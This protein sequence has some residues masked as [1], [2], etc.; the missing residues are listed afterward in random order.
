RPPPPSPPTAQLEQPPP[1]RRPALV[2]CPSVD[3][4]M[5]GRL[6]ESSGF[7]SS[8]PPLNESSDTGAGEG[9]SSFCDS[10]QPS[11]DGPGAGVE[12]SSEFLSPTPPPVRTRAA[13]GL[14]RSSSALYARAPAIWWADIGSSSLAG[15]A[16]NAVY[17]VAK[18]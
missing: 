4:F 3:F 8:S 13:S 2:V 16:R 15:M 6:P 7:S 14:R 17:G 1:L 11:R 18:L 5:A 9:D 10:V 12:A